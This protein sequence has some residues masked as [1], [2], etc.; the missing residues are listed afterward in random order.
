MSKPLS[1]V[2]ST[3]VDRLQRRRRVPPYVRASCIQSY[4]MLLIPF[5][6]FVLFAAFPLAWSIQKSFYSWNGIRWR[7]A[8]LEKYV[9]VLTDRVFHTAVA[10]TFIFL[11]KLVVEIP[12]AFTL[13]VILSRRFI[14]RNL[15]RGALF[16]PSVTSIAVMSVVF[17]VI[18]QPYSGF[19]NQFLMKMGVI[20]A[21]IDWLGTRLTALGSCMAISIWQYTGL[22]M[23]FILAGLQSIPVEYY[24]AGQIEGMNWWQ[25]VWYITIPSIAPY[26]QVIVML[27][28]I[29]TMKVA[30]LILVLTNGGPGYETEMMMT[31]VFH[32]FWGSGRGEKA[33]ADWGMGAAG[34]VISGIIVAIVT[35]IYLYTTRKSS[36]YSAD[37]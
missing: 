24:E 36:E 6:G 1:P 35:L 7:P 19:I 27:G 2:V 32:H 9:D 15:V 12:L 37:V 21:P 3:D 17:Y 31:Y 28:I 29:G 5:L 34:A 22:N 10:N 8:G 14:G 11:L 25:S 18:L 30:D 13:A 26:L 4:L 16:L 23:L 20:R 33:V